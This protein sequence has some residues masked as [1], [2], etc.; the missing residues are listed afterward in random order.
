VLCWRVHNTP[1]SS[2]P[3]R[4]CSELLAPRLAASIVVK[5]AGA[6]PVG[7]GRRGRGPVSSDQA[8]RGRLGAEPGDAPRDERPLAPGGAR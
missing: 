1:H 5:R 8:A 6:A 4:V 2:L 7:G 3:M